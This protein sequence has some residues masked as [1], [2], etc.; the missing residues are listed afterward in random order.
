[1][2][3]DDQLSK[4][5]GKISKNN[6]NNKNIHSIY[7]TVKLEQYAIYEIDADNVII[8]KRNDR[9]APSS[10][11]EYKCFLENVEIVK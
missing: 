5:S 10:D 8:R 6:K 4:N 7:G 2:H 3:V 11:Q 9:I 1:M